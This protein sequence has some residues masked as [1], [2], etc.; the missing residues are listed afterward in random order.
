MK[1]H[2]EKLLILQEVAKLV[3]F[4]LA[5]HWKERRPGRLTCYR[6]GQ[7]IVP[8]Q[9]HLNSKSG[10]WVRDGSAD[11]EGRG[12]MPAGVKNNALPLLKLIVI[13]GFL[14]GLS[15]ALVGIWF[16]YL[17]ASADTRFALS[18]A[19]GKPANLGLLSVIVGARLIRLSFTG[20][21]RKL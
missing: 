14:A 1:K 9:S 13:L 4:C 8:D 11:A 12:R 6:L 15:F 18:C 3:A 7:K 5:I 17:G 20:A 21:L 19:T 2:R 16:V 10:L